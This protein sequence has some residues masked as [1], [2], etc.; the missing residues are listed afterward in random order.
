MNK[1]LS[2]VFLLIA[3]ITSAIAF[4]ITF[5]YNSASSGDDE[6]LFPSVFQLTDEDKEWI[7]EKVQTMSLREKCA[8]MI[9][10]PVYREDFDTSS[11]GYKNI[12]SL[13][14]DDK[15]GGLILYQGELL[16]QA[17]FIKNMQN[18]SDIPL[19][20]SSDFERGLGSRIDDATEFPHAMALGSTHNTNYA[21]EMGKAIAIECRILGVHQNFAPVADINSNPLNPIINIRSFS[22]DKNEVADFVTAFIK[23]SQEEK[24]ITTAKH[25]PGHGNTELDSHYDLPKINGNKNHL[26]QNELLPFIK[27]IEAGVQSIMIG[28][29]EVPSFETEKGLPATLSKSIVTN[30]LKSKLNFTGII[31]TDAMIMEAVTKNYS[32]EEATLMAVNAG[33]DII[34]MPPDAVKAIEAIYEA[35]LNGKITEERIDES[36]IKIL[37][38]KRW[39]KIENSQLQNIDAI[40]DSIDIAEHKLL[41]KKIAENSVTLIKNNEMLIP[42]KLDSYTNIFC[43]SVT[44]EYWKENAE[45]FQKMVEDR[46]GKVTS[47]VLSSNSN[48]Y[49]YKTALEDIKKADMIILPAYLGY[50]GDN[51]FLKLL[52]EQTK[53]IADVLMTNIPVVLISF[54]N[55]YLLYYF[56]EAKTYLNTYSHS[57]PSQ[58]AV[59]RALMGEIG[60][61]GKLPVTIPESDF[62]YGFGIEIQQSLST[63]IDSS[64]INNNFREFDKKI[65]NAIDENVFPGA[66]VL[67]AKNGRINY[68]KSFGNKDYTGNSSL[69]KNHQFNVANLSSAITILL[70]VFQLIDDGLI[71][72]EDY[73]SYYIEETDTTA[74]RDIKIKNLLLH[75]SGIDNKLY[76]L[77]SNWSKDEL[78]NAIYNQKPAAPVEKMFIFSKLNYILLQK[79]IEEVADKNLDEYVSENIFNPLKLNNT[80]FRKTYSSDKNNIFTNSRG[81][82]HIITDDE[83]IMKIMKGVCGYCGLYSTAADLAVIAQMIIQKGYY[84]DKQIIPA[85]YVLNWHKFVDESAEKNITSTEKFFKFIDPAGCFLGIDM[86]N[87]ITVIVLAHTGMHNPVNDNF[88]VFTNNLSQTIYKIFSGKN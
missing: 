34:L 23:G 19:L 43:L 22:E 80:V 51:N 11:D 40:K 84:D 67:A 88:K 14:K 21:F 7:N 30:L 13:I 1:K 17:G 85:K 64:N 5:S 37:S 54:R 25:F 15:I 79:I 68:F 71:N 47:I 49:E 12:L 41:S 20:I 72:L 78:L 76:N 73:I 31:I 16:E 65:L 9:M 86:Q 61:N 48:K 44:D 35:V 45:E 33:N 28:H 77:T 83:A 39:L 26:R 38:A 46:I 50:T 42:L 60:V 62:A 59:L 32:V 18:I 3:L 58:K 55:P 56:P 24:I 70:P 57:V 36:V 29:L 6:K 74:L 63:I 81:I 82:P 66:V 10:P 75:N 69:T 52:P 53:F 2:I 4:S 27:A 8:Q 87:K